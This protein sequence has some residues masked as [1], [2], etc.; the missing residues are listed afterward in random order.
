MIR[1]SLLILSLLQ[2]ANANAATGADWWKNCPGPACPAREADS[3]YEKSEKTNNDS[4]RI[5]SEKMRKEEERHEKAIDKIEKEEP[6]RDIN[7]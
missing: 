3:S 1:H 5:D 7:R 2:I 6:R 4:E